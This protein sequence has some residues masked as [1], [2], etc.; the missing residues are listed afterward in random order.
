[1]AAKGSTMEVKE[2]LQEGEEEGAEELHLETVDRK[3]L[4]LL[5]KRLKEQLLGVAEEAEVAIWAARIQVQAA[6]LMEEAVEELLVQDCSVVAVLSLEEQAAEGEEREQMG[7]WV[8]SEAFV[9]LAR[10]VAF[11]QSEEA[12]PCRLFFP[13]CL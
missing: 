12:A 11:S 1:M 13:G 2:P 8:W 10:E 3:L 5:E 4:M 6:Q 9:M 7:R